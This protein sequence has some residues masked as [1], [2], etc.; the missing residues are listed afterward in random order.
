[1]LFQVRRKGMK[2][3]VIICDDERPACFLGVHQTKRVII[4]RTKGQ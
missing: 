3:S 4:A 2:V 1:M